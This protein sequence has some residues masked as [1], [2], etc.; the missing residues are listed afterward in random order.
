MRVGLGSDHRGRAQ[1]D[2]AAAWLRS[3]GHEAVD[4]GV[5]AEGPVDYPD[6]AFP[7]AERVSRGELDRGVL[8]C[9]TG[10]GMAIAANKVPGVRAAV[11]TD[12]AVARRTR[13]HNDSNI[14]VLAAE[15]TPP[16][17]VGPLLEAFLE[18]HYE[19]GRHDRRLAK[20]HE[21]ELRHTALGE[22]GRP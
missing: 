13:Q 4:F 3:H 14:L 21:Y 7:V 5:N 6:Y 12:P 18:A 19:G 22:T 8:V 10:I 1:K 9:D 11:V 2:A 20:I 16:E 15:S 17:N